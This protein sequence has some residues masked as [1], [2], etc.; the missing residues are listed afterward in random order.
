MIFSSTLLLLIFNNVYSQNIA[1]GE[2]STFLNELLSPEDRKFYETAFK[3]TQN[4]G[5]GTQGNTL[6]RSESVSSY[7]IKASS[8]SITDAKNNELKIVQEDQ[9]GKKETVIEYIDKSENPKNPTKTIFKKN[10]G[11]NYV[12]TISDKENE[13]VEFD[14]EK[15]KSI[16]NIISE[17]SKLQSEKMP[18]KPILD[19]EELI[20]RDI[21]KEMAEER[22][23]IEKQTDEKNRILQ[24]FY[25]FLTE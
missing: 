18:T 25:P 20:K 17:L 19:F 1:S 5:D 6:Q 16:D 21:I 15:T 23:K 11:G 8:F 22:K 9:N 2:D 3:L 14:S 7:S 12:R 13:K 10:D 24:K 4:P